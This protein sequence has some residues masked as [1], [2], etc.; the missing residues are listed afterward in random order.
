MIF[1]HLKFP[2]YSF[3]KLFLNIKYRGCQKVKDNMNIIL[4]VTS[5]LGLRGH[6][7]ISV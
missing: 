3:V 6:W 4:Y 2:V 5:V 1:Y 7:I